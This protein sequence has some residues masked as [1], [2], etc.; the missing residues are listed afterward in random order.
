MLS[1]VSFCGGAICTVSICM[2]LT[3]V[4]SAEMINGYAVTSITCDHDDDWLAVVQEEFGP[5]ATVADWNDL[6]AY[7]ASDPSAMA[8]LLGGEDRNSAYVTLNGNQY[9][10]PYSYFVQNH[11]GNVPSGW[12][13]LDQVGNNVVDLGRW[14]SDGYRVFAANV[15]VGGSVPEPSS[16]TLL[17]LGLLGLFVFRRRR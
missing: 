4:A 8:D 9:V 13:V 2:L 3:S 10:G 6:K 7:F 17:L 15:P 16:L 14:D 11:F 1:K 5:N 12:A